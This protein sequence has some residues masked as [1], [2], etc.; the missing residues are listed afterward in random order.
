MRKNTASLALIAVLVVGGLCAGRALGQ[1][2]SQSPDVAKAAADLKAAMQNILFPP[3][4]NAQTEIR[5]DGIIVQRDANGGAFVYQIDGPGVGIYRDAGGSTSTIE[6][7]E[8]GNTVTTDTNGVRTVS[9]PNT[10]PLLAQKKMMSEAMKKALGATDEEWK[11]LEPRIE[12]VKNL[13]KS[14]RSGGG[15]MIYGRMMDNGFEFGG[16]VS[17]VQKAARELA[18]VLASKDSSPGDIK[19]AITALHEAKAKAKIELEK[20]LKDLKE[21]ISIRQEAQLIQM[22]VL[23]E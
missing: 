7:D 10:N 9:D 17:D 14:I 13:S 22:G 5:A 12:K 8:K 16:K 21:I 20:A 15:M 2:T 11:V 19:A 18:R 6:I 3:I 23:T 4:R 1:A